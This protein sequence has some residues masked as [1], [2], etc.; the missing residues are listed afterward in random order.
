M[1]RRTVLRVG[2]WSFVAVVAV[3]GLGAFYPGGLPTLAGDLSDYNR[4]HAELVEE[5]KTRMV[6][7]S[8]L[9]SRYE[10]Y[11]LLVQLRGGLATGS[12]RLPLAADEYLTSVS[13]S[14][15][16]LLQYRYNVPGR[17]DQERMAVV[18][19]RDLFA[20]TLL[21]SDQQAQLLHQFHTTYAVSYPLPLPVATG[22]NTRELSSQ[23]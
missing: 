7:D 15:D 11:E 21:S 23:P 4:H 8:A 16:L 6:I 1:Q 17:S 3:L 20:N 9:A 13:A 18:L 22:R 2:G 12:V 5:Q 10:R 14:P 19:L